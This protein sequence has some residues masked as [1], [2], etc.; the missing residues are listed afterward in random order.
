MRERYQLLLN[1]LDTLMSSKG[2]ENYQKRK[3]G[4]IKDDQTFKELILAQN[5]SKKSQ[6]ND[7]EKKYYR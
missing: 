2:T 3:V 1:G 7:D 5:N 4:A 6:E